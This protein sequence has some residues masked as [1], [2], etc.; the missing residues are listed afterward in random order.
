MWG[1]YESAVLFVLEGVWCVKKCCFSPGQVLPLGLIWRCTLFSLTGRNEVM[2]GAIHCA[3]NRFVFYKDPHTCAQS[4]EF[5]WKNC[6]C[7]GM[8]HTP[9]RWLAPSGVDTEVWFQ[10][11]AVRWLGLKVSWSFC[12]LVCVN[13]C[14][15]W[16]R[17]EIAVKTEL[18]GLT[19]VREMLVCCLY[20]LVYKVLAKFTNLLASLTWG[21][22]WIWLHNKHS[23]ALMFRAFS[24]QLS[25]AK[26]KSTLTKWCNP[27]FCYITFPASYW[28]SPSNHLAE[29]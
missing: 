11:L 14:L 17:R 3:V 6:N 19:C 7:A 5:W 25:S 20:L 16:G 8:S 18:C 4:C 13:A 9:H 12:L 26:F 1:K 23:S 24:A 22:S 21:I 10:W 29:N 28:P 15:R 27:L 2:E